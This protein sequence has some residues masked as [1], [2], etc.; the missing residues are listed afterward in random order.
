MDKLWYYHNPV[1][2][3]KTWNVVEREE[4]GDGR[5]GRSLKILP[6]THNVF[7]NLF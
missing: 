1:L 5:M 6:L 7:T 4:D 3:A 2:V